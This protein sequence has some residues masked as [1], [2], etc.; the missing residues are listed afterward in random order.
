MIDKFFKSESAGGILLVLAAVAAL[1]V[2]NSELYPLYHHVLEGVVFRVGFN[3]SAGYDFELRKNILHWINDGL[4]ALFFFVVGLEIKK[5][6]VDGSLSS[7]RQAALPVIAAIG[8]MAAPALVYLYIVQDHAELTGGWAISSATDIAFALGILS[9]LGS[10]VPVSLKMLLTAIAVIDDLGAIIIIALFYTQKISV[11]PLIIAAIAIVKLFTLNRAGVRRIGPYAVLGLVMWAAVL[12]SGVHA[13]LAGAATAMFIPAH[14]C[15]KS[16][17]SPNQKLQHALHPW[18]AFLVLPLF[19]FA[20][21][22][23]PFSGIGSS[24]LTHPVVAGIIGGL[25]IGK[26]VG[27]LGTVY[28]ST[29]MG[30]CEK[31]ADV[32]WRHMAGMSLLCGIGFTMSLFIGTLAFSPEMQSLVRLGVLGGS[33]LSA[34]AG[35]IVLRRAS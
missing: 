25:F 5:E 34:V 14:G 7:W 29:R 2:A 31:P 35:Y 6:I 12:Q 33:L 17:E 15:R 9:I 27:V 23:V 1:I 13:T 18:I 22:G 16:D 8:G 19:A 26:F 10:R 4:M 20:N 30:L 28:L 32:S 11:V 3:D 24:S 21:A